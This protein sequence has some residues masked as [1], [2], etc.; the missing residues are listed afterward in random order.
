MSQLLYF[1]IKIRIRFQMEDL[2]GL[3]LRSDLNV[4]LTIFS[5]TT[6]IEVPKK[7]LVWVRS[8]TECNMKRIVFHSFFF[9]FTL[10]YEVI[11]P[12]IRRFALRKYLDIKH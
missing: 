12:R 9:V 3:E 4:D 11:R 5:R 7:S 6:L 1:L 2:N 10:G 8:Y